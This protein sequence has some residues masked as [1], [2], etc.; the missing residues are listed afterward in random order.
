MERKLYIFRIHLR[1]IPNVNAEVDLNLD[2]SLKAFILRVL[3]TR[4]TNTPT[5]LLFI[6]SHINT[7]YTILSYCLFNAHHHIIMRFMVHIY[8]NLLKNSFIA[9]D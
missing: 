7:L 1:F 5:C 9:F 6:G 4:H 8:E 2:S 3:A